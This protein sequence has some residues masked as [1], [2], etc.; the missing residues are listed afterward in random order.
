MTIDHRPGGVHLDGVIFFDIWLGAVHFEWVVC[1]DLKI[2]N[3]WKQ[4]WG[5]WYCRIISITYQTHRP[6][7]IGRCGGNMI[8]SHGYH[9]RRASEQAAAHQWHPERWQDDS[10]EPVQPAGSGGETNFLE[11][12]S[13][14]FL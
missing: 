12:A 1:F 8:F 5:I 13:G 10:L 2:M 3:A 7:Q 14:C 6:G 9:L 11:V 4:W